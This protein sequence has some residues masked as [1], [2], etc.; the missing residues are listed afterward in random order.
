M[1]HCMYMYCYADQEKKTAEETAGRVYIW[2]WISSLRRRNYKKV[3]TRMLHGHARVRTCTYAHALLHRINICLEIPVQRPHPQSEPPR[4]VHTPASPPSDKNSCCEPPRAMN[5]PASPPPDKNSC[6]EP[7]WAMHAPTSPPPDKI[8]CSE[9]PF[10][11]R[12][13][14]EYGLLCMRTCIYSQ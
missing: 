7:P 5:A 3:L 8:S 1:V 2:T 10:L 9:P 14:W 6:S 11:A 13:L 4:A 12:N